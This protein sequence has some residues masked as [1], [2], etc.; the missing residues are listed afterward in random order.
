MGGTVGT[1]FSGYLLLNLY[2]LFLFFDWIR[3]ALLNETYQITRDDEN[4]YY[5]IA[6]TNAGTILRVDYV[7]GLVTIVLKKDT[8]IPDGRAL[9]Y[10]L[11]ITLNIIE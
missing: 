1:Y 4:K 7:S 6:N 5:Y 10:C 9:F 3:S 2:K 11:Y 8:L